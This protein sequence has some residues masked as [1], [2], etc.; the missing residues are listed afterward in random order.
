L[1]KRIGVFAAIFFLAAALAVP[2]AQAKRHMLIGMQDD[3]M[4]LNGNPGV[5]FNTLK[6]LRVQIVR[7]NLNWNQV[8]KRRPAHPQ[9]PADPAYDWDLYDRADR[10]AAQNGMQ[11]LLTFLFVPSWANGGKA[12]T[13]RTPTARTRRISRR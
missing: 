12:T 2:A 8:A 6:Q 7:V 9:D 3:A 5:T 1:H 13:S 11:L 10:Y 4:T